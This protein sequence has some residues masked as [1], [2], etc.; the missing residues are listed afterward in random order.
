MKIAIVYDWFDKW[1]GVE[2]LLL[3]LHQ[4]FPRATFFTS[5]FNPQNAFW[6]RKWK[7]QTSFIQ[8][9]PNFIKTNRIFS[10]PFYPF[11]FE[12]FNFD[13][14]DIVISVSSSFAKGVITKPK[15]FHICYLMTP[16]RFLWFMSREYRA[17][18][19][20]YFKKWDYIGAQRPDKIIAISQ[21]ASKRCLKFYKR[22][23]EVIYPPFDF[24]YWQKIKSQLFPL[25]FQERFTK[26][27]SNLNNYY[28]VVSRLEPYKK[29][30]LVIKLFR[31]LSYNLIV[32]GEGSLKRKL[33]KMASKNI[34]FFSNVDDQKL[35]WLYSQAK[36]LIMPQEEDFGYVA[37]E[38]Q[39]FGTPVIAYGKG[40][41]KETIIEE[42]T[43]LFFDKQNE[44]SLAKILERFELISYNLRHSTR[45]F[46]LKNIKKF[47]KKIFVR[48]FLKLI[49]INKGG[50]S[51][52]FKSA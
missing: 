25:N 18:N 33:Q 40:G 50:G 42:K 36:A 23:S 38:S 12:S 27:V 34:I 24:D 52:I 26:L 9:L 45:Q 39:F 32:V 17:P 43:G 21:T 30:D 20:N 37:I 11:A 6:A 13:Q 5:Y 29:V 3:I 14:Y 8:N 4:I 46:G 1:G 31:K 49:T 44:E 48:K 15:T 35:A 7:I 47:E 19:I 28:L 16:T 2:R 10:L 51:K 22:K 41:A